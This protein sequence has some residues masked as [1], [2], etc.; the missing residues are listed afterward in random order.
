MAPASR[1]NLMAYGAQTRRSGS[2]LFLPVVL[3]VTATLLQ[4]CSSWP[5]W[6]LGRASPSLPAQTDAV[7]RSSMTFAKSPHAAGECIVANAKGAGAA[8][9]L[10]PLYGLESVAVTV[11]TRVAGEHLAVFSLTRNDSGA[12]AE[13]TTW[14]GVPDRQDLLRKLTQGC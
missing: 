14:A 11:T 8:A 12:H 5:R 1:E 2:L 7:E 6:T 13:T 9:D 10:V 4:G 3:A